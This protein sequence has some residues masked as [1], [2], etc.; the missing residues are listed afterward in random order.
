MTSLELQSKKENSLAHDIKNLINGLNLQSYTSFSF[1]FISKEL[2]DNIHEKTNIFVEMFEEYRKIVNYDSTGSHRKNANK[3]I[4]RFLLKE[5]CP[6]VKEYEASFFDDKISRIKDTEDQEIATEIKEAIKSTSS[7]LKRKFNE[8]EESSRLVGTKGPKK[9]RL[10]LSEIIKTKMEIVDFTEGVT[11]KPHVGIW[12]GSFDPQEN[13]YH[14]KADKDSIESALENIFRNAL[15][16]AKYHE[17]KFVGADIEKKD[18]KI[19]FV[20]YNNGPAMPEDLKDLAFTKGV[21]DPKKPGSSGFGLPHAKW[22]CDI[23]G[24]SIQVLK[25]GDQVPIKLHGL[26]Q[27][28]VESA[29]KFKDEN[30]EV[31]PSKLNVFVFSFPVYP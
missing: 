12:D 26:N 4:K 9:T 23:N 8:F 5:I 13:K 25:A 19:I 15:Q 3:E 6:L 24:A 7:E 22:C 30:G 20:Q 11:D 27:L 17:G 1:G 10:N 2:K 18:D 14:I 16:H 21:R 29:Q 28:D 31:D